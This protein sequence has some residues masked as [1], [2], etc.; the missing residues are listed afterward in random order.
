MH[1]H[2]QDQTALGWQRETHSPD[3]DPWDQDNGKYA[4]CIFCWLG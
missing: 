1:K 3:C 4:V 2:I